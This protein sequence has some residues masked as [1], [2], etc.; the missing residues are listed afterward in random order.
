M[1]DGQRKVILAKLETALYNNVNK[2]PLFGL[3]NL[4]QI[5]P[6]QVDP[7]TMLDI[8]I[9]GDVSRLE[10]VRDKTSGELL[11]L[12]EEPLKA[13]DDFHYDLTSKSSV[14]MKRCATSTQTI[15]GSITSLP[16]KPPAL[17]LVEVNKEK[18]PSEEISITQFLQQNLAT[19]ET[20]IPGTNVKN[21]FDCEETGRD[22]LFKLDEEDVAE[23]QEWIQSENSKYDCLSTIIKSANLKKDETSE[24]LQTDPKKEKGQ[25][26]EIQKLANRVLNISIKGADL[27]ENKSS[28]FAKVVNIAKEPDEEI[29]NPAKTYGFKLDPFQKQAILHMEKFCNVFVAAHTSA[30]KT[31]VAEYAIAMA[32]RSMTK[33]VYTSPIKALS[34]QKYRDFTLEFGDV[35]LI[36]GDVQVNTDASCLIL[37]TEILLQM[38]DN[39]SDLIRDLEWAIFDEV[40]YVNDEER[41]HVWER[42]FI[43]LPEHVNLVLLS[44]TVPNVI[45]FAEWLGRIR[46]KPTVVITTV[47]RPVPLEHYLYT[48]SNASTMDQRYKFIDSSSDF[49]LDG[50]KKAIDAKKDAA[51]HMKGAKGKAFYMNPQQEKNIYVTLVRH[52]E[53]NSLLPVICF[54][55]SRRRCDANARML[56]SLDLTTGEEKAR[57]HKFVTRSLDRFKESDRKLRQV[58]ALKEMLKRG[59]G[60][61]HSGVLPLL[62]EITEILF[63][64]GLVKVLFATETFA[65]GVN[66]PARSVVFDSIKKHDGRY[67]R[68]LLPSEYIQ[69]AGRAGRRGKDLVG[70][71]IILCKKE[72]PEASDLISIALGKPTPLESRFQLKYS[73]ILTLLRARHHLKVESVIGKSFI[74]HDKQSTMASNQAKQQTLLKQIGSFRRP[75]C[76]ICSDGKMDEF[77]EYFLKFMRTPHYQDVRFEIF[78]QIF[79]KKKIIPGRTMVVIGLDSDP[80]VIGPNPAALG[81]IVQVWNNLN[82][83]SIEVLHL[84]DY[85]SG[86]VNYITDLGYHQ[87]LLVLK[88]TISAKWIDLRDEKELLNKSKA[89]S[90]AA[91]QMRDYLQKLQSPVQLFNAPHFHPYTDLNLRQLEFVEAFDHY[92][93]EQNGL[94]D[95]S[96]WFCPQFIQH[97]Q[98]FFRKH[99]NLYDLSRIEF[100]LSPEN[101]FFLPE[102]KRKLEV[103]RVLNYINEEN[104]PELKAK[105]ACLMSVHELVITEMLT[106]NMLSDCTPAEIAALLSVFVYQQKQVEEDVPEQ[107]K[108]PTTKL[109]RKCQELKKIAEK[110]GTIQRECGLEQTVEDFVDSLKFG[111][112]EVVH[113]WAEGSSF[114]EILKI[115]EEQEGII[116]RCIQ[117]LDEVLR[118]VKAACKLIGYPDICEKIEI[119]NQSI[120]R[121]IVFAASL[122]VCATQP[123]EGGETVESQ[124]QVDHAQDEEESGN[125]E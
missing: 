28:E 61:H 98:L 52:L 102:Y 84:K 58:V 9:L 18:A 62:K 64:D 118:A 5:I 6:Y 35:G 77:C 59:F 53:K 16:F 116:V 47:K 75:E 10:F 2:I 95:Y 103:L 46:K 1:D 12:T 71:V 73:M 112:V 29:A 125:K 34:N 21:V 31:V 92:Q 97:F 8:S 106:E 66:M 23:L 119:A 113:S 101:L 117:R 89:I 54:T 51:K 55:F 60:V 44:A 7:A 81:V 25:E 57:I 37:T 85:S 76:D 109:E 69:M 108:K 94:Q 124:Y 11:D 83:P 104:V 72:V 42:I 36:T 74:E 43:M 67:R 30:G 20:T 86:K 107:E 63:C 68:Y 40:H 93:L 19:L 48:G 13:G 24:S 111:L 38:L 50:Y 110:V 88:D 49:V 14:S 99:Y 3:Q 123:D 33:V 100:A 56:Q 45:K 82:P 22:E 96:C 65:M 15:T 122:Y 115:T 120:N 87:V 105:V 27:E 32:R 17:D 91:Q 26:K 79:E 70:T 41:G 4:Q 121:D 78:S 90:K 39:G 80:A 114:N